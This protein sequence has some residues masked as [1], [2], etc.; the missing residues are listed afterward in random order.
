MDLHKNKWSVH[1]P[2]LKKAE[3]IGVNMGYDCSEWLEKEDVPC[4]PVHTYNS[5]FKDPQVEN[6]RLVTRLPH[7]VLGEVK[8][9]GNPVRFSETPMVEHSAAPV[10]GEHTDQIF[11]GLGF[12]KTEIRELR[13]KKII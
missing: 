4:G 12:S 5:L 10:L 8:N 9:V 1:T 11:V 3:A 13:K 7:S 6:N 2:W